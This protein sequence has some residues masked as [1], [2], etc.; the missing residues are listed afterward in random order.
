MPYDPLTL[1]NLGRNVELALLATDPV[2][3]IDV[4]PTIGAGAY[5]IYYTGDHPLYAPISSDKCEIPIYVGKAVAPGG[6]K[7]LVD[8]SKDTD[9][10]WKRLQEHAESLQQARDFDVDDFLV[11]YLVAV[12]IF[13]PLAER[14]MI[15]QLQP[16]WNLRL[17]GFGNHDPGENRRPKSYRPPWDELHPGRWWSTPENMPTP[18]R[19][20]R[21]ESIRDI[22][23]HFETLRQR[24]V[25][26]ASPS[27]LDE[28]DAHDMFAG[29]LSES[30]AIPGT[31]DT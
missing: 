19:V 15:R 5:T 12:E 22:Q 2:P 18:S 31:E 23:A 6:R 11:R 29:I 14:V 1:T 30:D 28:D 13:V 4:P 16:V 26:I 20:T 21:E 3:I 27:A 24:L 25:N 8:D 9:A 10:L 17:D 7:G